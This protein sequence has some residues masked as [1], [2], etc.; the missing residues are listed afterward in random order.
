[1]A[2]SRLTRTLV[3]LILASRRSPQRRPR[4]TE[5]WQ[6]DTAQGSTRRAETQCTVPTNTHHPPLT[7]QNCV[8]N[9]PESSLL[10]TGA[11]G[12][13][14]SGFAR[15][16]VVN[17]GTAAVDITLQVFSFDVRCVAAAIAG[18]GNGAGS[19]YTGDT[20][21][22]T[23][24]RLTDHTIP[25]PPGALGSACNNPPGNPPCAND[26]V[27]DFD[28]DVPLNTCPR[29]AASVHPE[30][31]VSAHELQRRFSRARDQP[32]AHDVEELRRIV[33]MDSGADSV[34]GVGSGAV[35]LGAALETSPFPGTGLFTP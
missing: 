22:R 20:F 13:P 23:P 8:P 1:M 9:V 25:G 28:L 5:A 26:T 24:L 3:L 30:A 14:A 35:R 15:Y 32:D 33:L 7:R 29:T 16:K 31:R 17:P 34:I 21:L 2:L 6:R 11:S 18:C 10:M 19:D 12:S 4:L 27:T